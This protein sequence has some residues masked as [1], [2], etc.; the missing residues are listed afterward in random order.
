MHA[1]THAVRN[2]TDKGIY[3]IK[4]QSWFELRAGCERVD[5]KLYKMRISTISFTFIDTGLNLF[6]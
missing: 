1:Q 4:T 2:I 3:S 6:I 5:E